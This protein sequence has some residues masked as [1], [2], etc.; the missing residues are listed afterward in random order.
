MTKLDFNGR[1]EGLEALSA[2][3]PT[4]I[5]VPVSMMPTPFT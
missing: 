4:L 2:D 3:A 5:E 1:S